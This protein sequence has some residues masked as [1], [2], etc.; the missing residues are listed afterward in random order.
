MCLYVCT[1][2]GQRSNI[3]SL[4]QLL[5]TYASEFLCNFGIT[6]M[7]IYLFRIGFPIGL[8]LADLI[9]WS[10]WLVGKHPVL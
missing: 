1:G 2:G 9:W 4:P 7:F 8:K 5:S 10:D 3:E 6:Y